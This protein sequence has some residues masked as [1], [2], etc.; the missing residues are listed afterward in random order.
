MATVGD[1]EILSANVDEPRHGVWFVE[2][3]LDGSSPPVAGDAVTVDLDGTELSGTVTRSDVDST[4]AQ[5]RVV[6]GTAGLA[7]PVTS[8]FYYQPTLALVLSQ[9]LK[10]AGEV[11]SDE[12]RD[13]SSL[14]VQR[15]T[16]IAGT[17]SHALD[18]LVTA[19]AELTGEEL[20]W[21][22]QRDGTIWLGVDT[23]EEAD[24]EY[25][26]E[27]RDGG[28][29]TVT[30]AP[31]DDVLVR[32]GESLGGLS[33]RHAHTS[34]SADGLRQTLS[35]GEDRVVAILRAFVR[36]YTQAALNYRAFY[37]ATVVRV[38]SDGTVD[39]A[40][41]DEQLGRSTGGLSFVPI[42]YGFPGWSVEPS[43]GSRCLVGFEDGDPQR[44]YVDHWLPGTVVQA[45][46]EGGTQ[47]MAR[48]D[49]SVSTG[50]VTASANLSTGVVTF[51]HVP[52]SGPPITSTNLDLSLG[53][54]TSGNDKLKA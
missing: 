2:A 27:S 3:V 48:V 45:T 8:R 9:L 53:Q 22:V 6:G 52:P 11:L 38:Q 15:W 34:W 30:I 16:R 21:R 49:D 41:D 43:Q 20:V 7:K 36:R 18:E 5:V 17:A 23:Y 42:R 1:L 51:V 31:E 26:E 13:L 28:K 44:P 14:R 54:I 47:S 50:Q 33:I 35:Y 12:S 39:L 29:R 46:F 4:R 32:P 25:L 24:V 40:P 10:E 37:K 19:A